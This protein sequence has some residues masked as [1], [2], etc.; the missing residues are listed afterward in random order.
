MAEQLILPR[1]IARGLA[2]TDHNGDHWPESWVAELQPYGVVGIEANRHTGEEKRWTSIHELVIRTNDR[3]LW[4]RLYEVGLTER[5]YEAPFEY[6]GENIPFDEVRK[7]PV[8][9]HEY[10][11]V[12]TPTVEVKVG[13]TYAERAIEFK[14][15]MRAD[16]EG[17]HDWLKAY[18]RRNGEPRW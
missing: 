9:A 14:F 4:R 3:R 10:V 16:P 2:D 7:Q 11:P 5:Q 1:E 17:F 18:A 8:E 15:W 12:A 13:P 6:E